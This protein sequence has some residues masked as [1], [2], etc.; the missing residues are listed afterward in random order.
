MGKGDY[1]EPPSG[2]KGAPAKKSEIRSQ[3]SSGKHTVIVGSFTDKL[4][5][6]KLVDQ[7]NKEKY[8][9]EII[10]DG[11]NFKVGVKF[12]DL[13]SAQA[14]LDELKTKYPGSWLM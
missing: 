2:E 8:Q 14:G 3:K 13:K 9:T 6:E 1:S 12:K 7:L 4:N 11:I 5:A 10:S